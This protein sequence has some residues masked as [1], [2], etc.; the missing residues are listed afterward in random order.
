[1]AN[2]SY[3]VGPTLMPTTTFSML[4]WRHIIYCIMRTGFRAGAIEQN[5]SK[6]QRK[7]PKTL[8]FFCLMIDNIPWVFCLFW[9]WCCRC[10]FV[11]HSEWNEQGI[12]FESSHW[13]ILTGCL[14]KSMFHFKMADHDGNPNPCSK[15]MFNE[16]NEMKADNKIAQNWLRHYHVRMAANNCKVTNGRKQ[17]SRK[18]KKNAQF[19]TGH[20][21]QMDAR[22]FSSACFVH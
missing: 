9:C 2:T 20:N 6:L 18:K 13:I 11:C 4:C 12:A 21:S 16:L 7:Q 17:Q 10:C 1:M 22:N 3:S 5:C 15:L 14:I 19:R 8:S